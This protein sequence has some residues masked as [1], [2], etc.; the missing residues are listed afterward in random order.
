MRQRLFI[1]LTD[2]DL[3]QRLREVQTKLQRIEQNQKEI[4]RY[5][6]ECE[7]QN[8]VLLEEKRH[9]DAPKLITGF[10]E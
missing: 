4:D 7:W 3:N 6:K 2:S 5:K 9:R 1:N 8:E 10:E